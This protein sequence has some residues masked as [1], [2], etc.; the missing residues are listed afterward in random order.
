MSSIRGLHTLSYDVNLALLCV[1][2]LSFVRV[3]TQA[4]RTSH[5]D[6][7]GDGGGRE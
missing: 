4:Q 3:V 2:L 5:T 7:G 1:S 6:G